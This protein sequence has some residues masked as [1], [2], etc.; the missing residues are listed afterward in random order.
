MS[1]YTASADLYDT[2][3]SASAR[4]WFVWR[5]G[6]QTPAGLDHRDQKFAPL[7]GDSAYEALLEGLRNDRNRCQKSLLLALPQHA[8]K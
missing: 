8:N 2:T 5:R 6:L 4:C 3:I 7:T 1:D